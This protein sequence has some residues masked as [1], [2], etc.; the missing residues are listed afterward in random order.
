MIAKKP[1]DFELPPELIQQYK[2]ALN[3]VS[4][5]RLLVLL[6]FNS[7]EE[8]IRSFAAWRLTCPISELPFKNNSHSLIEVILA[9][10][11]TK[12][13]LKRVEKFDL[14]K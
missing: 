12:S 2:E 11:P 14:V 6:L 1:I 3:T 9:G 8:I 7:F 10:S 4:D 5:V 13:L